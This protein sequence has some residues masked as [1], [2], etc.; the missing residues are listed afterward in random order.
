MSFLE[1]LSVFEYRR[2]AIGAVIIGIAA[3]M[4]GC[5]LYL[6]RQSMLADVVGHSSVAGVMG[7]FIGAS[8]L[9]VDGRSILVI[10]IGALVSGLLAVGLTDWVARVSRVRDDAA[11]AAS[12]ALFYGGG[13]ILLHII[14]HSTLPNRGGIDELMFGKVSTL[15]AAD[16][17]T[18][19]VIAF[20]VVLATVLLHRPFHTMLFDPV[21]AKLVLSPRRATALSIIQMVLIVCAVVLGIKSVGLILIIAFAI[22]PSVAARQWT[23]SL[24]TMM[25]LAALFG[26]VA[27]VLGSWLSVVGQ[28][29]PAG[30]VIVLVLTAIVLVSF[31]AA[32]RRGL[33][34]RMLRKSV[35]RS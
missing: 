28:G 10:V 27:G 7:A 35:V 33:I 5:H 6:R 23:R 31:I 22:F 14:Q 24:G 2:T 32:P 26:A 4:L 11:M 25:A 34:A 21:M 19:G 15:T 13:M 30:P 17:A 1:F 16:N 20:I 9:S 3:G 18:L 12:L 8:M 29:M